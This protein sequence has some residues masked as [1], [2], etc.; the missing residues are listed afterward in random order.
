MASKVRVRILQYC[1]SMISTCQSAL[2]VGNKSIV[3]TSYP[4]SR[5]TSA[6]LP[7]PENK[8]RA[9]GLPTPAS[10][11]T[12]AQ[13]RSKNSRSCISLTSLQASREPWRVISSLS[14]P[15]GYAHRDNTS[16]AALSGPGIYWMDRSN[17]DNT[18][19]QRA[20]SPGSCGGFHV[21]VHPMPKRLMIGPYL[22]WLKIN[23]AGPVQ[24]RCDDRI[25]LLVPRCPI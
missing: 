21:L 12:W 23:Y 11:R 2:Y 14:L 18:K 22:H 9:F 19:C 16:A 7:V 8:S 10:N 4:L 13:S 25:H 24:Q 3:T 15:A 20:P 5:K 17:R 1:H 6:T